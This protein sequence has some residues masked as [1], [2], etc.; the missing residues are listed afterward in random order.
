M[1]NPD[2]SPLAGGCL[3]GAIRYEA[4]GAPAFVAQC[5][6]RDCQLATGTGHTTI[7]GFPASRFL[8]S[9]TPSVYT[10]TGDTGGKV[11]RHFCPRCGS[12]LYTTGDHPGDLRIVQVG[13]LDEPGRVTPTAAI[14]VK[15]RIAWDIVDPDLPQYPAMIDTRPR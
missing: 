11:H 8:L 4:H 9:G 14:Y 3:C 13:T 10:S 6:C 7:A 1:A 12:R 15:D 5:F 2:L